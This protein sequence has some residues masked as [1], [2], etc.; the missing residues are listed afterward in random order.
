MNSI[1]IINLT[2]FKF[3]AGSKAWHDEYR[4]CT[5]IEILGEKRR[6]RVLRRGIK[7]M[8]FDTKIVLL[9][10]LKKLEELSDIS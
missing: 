8:V 3:P 10:E 2:D 4:V 7:E 6:I 9:S 5:I 1:N